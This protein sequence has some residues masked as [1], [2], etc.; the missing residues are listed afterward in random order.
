MN[1]ER[2]FTADFEVFGEKA[3]NPMDAEVDFLV[4][5]R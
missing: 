2:M 1:L 5:V 4:A 3:Q